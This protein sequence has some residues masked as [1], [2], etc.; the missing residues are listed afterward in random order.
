MSSIASLS[1][2]S[3]LL[4]FLWGMFLGGF[5][6][7]GLWLTVEKTVNSR[8]RILLFVASFILRFTVVVG[9]MYLVALVHWANLISCFVGLHFTRQILRKRGMGVSEMKQTIL[10]Q[11]CDGA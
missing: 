3:I 9:G 6:F 4:S 7:G 2:G 1:F 5:Y 10:K 11:G 8:Y